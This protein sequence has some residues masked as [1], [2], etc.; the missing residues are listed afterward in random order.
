M[1]T[2]NQLY[3]ELDEKLLKEHKEE[4]EES[5]PCG[6]CDYC[7]YCN[8]DDKEYPCAKAK[9]RMERERK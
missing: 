1:K 5:Y 8:P 6:Y 3:K 9:L 7:D 2:E 4:Y